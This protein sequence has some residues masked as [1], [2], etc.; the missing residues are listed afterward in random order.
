MKLFLDKL[1]IIFLLIPFSCV[2]QEKYSYRDVNPNLIN[3]HYEVKFYKKYP[4]RAYNLTQLLPNN[5]NYK[6]DCTEIIQ[7][8]FKNNRLIILPNFPISINEK[9]LYLFSNTKVYFQEKSEIIFIGQAKGRLNDILK[10]YDVENIEIYNP[11]IKGSKKSKKEQSGQWSAGICILNSKN[12][13]IYNAK[14]YDTWGDGIFVGSENGKTSENITLCGGWID[15]AGRNGISITS[16]KDLSISN[17]LISNTSGVLPMCGIDIEPSLF[18]E[19][20]NDIKIYDIT[21]FNNKNSALAVNLSNFTSSSKVYDK[22]ILI[23]IKNIKD[24]ESNIFLTFSLNPLN[25]KYTPKGKIN[26]TNSEAEY[27]KKA[28]W[29]HSA[30]SSTSVTLKNVKHKTLNN[31]KYLKY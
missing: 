12:I 10:I 16:A 26:I 17:I 7:E 9:G 11:Q 19:M 1:V 31:S 30:K 28:L 14:I 23:D 8:A 25:N 4:N 18:S 22:K 2:S 24:Y 3:K 20:L 5:Y 27:T 6:Q 29:K 15:N 21:T 13:K